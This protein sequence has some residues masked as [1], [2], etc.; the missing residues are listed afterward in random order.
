MVFK[1]NIKCNFPV[2]Y[3]EHNVGRANYED[4]YLMSHCKHHI[5]ANSSFSWWG[6]WLGCRPGKRVFYPAR[7]F[8]NVNV[9]TSTLCPLDWVRVE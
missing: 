3:I 9:D 6:A 1:E 5:I 7:W 4:L 2:E 8:A